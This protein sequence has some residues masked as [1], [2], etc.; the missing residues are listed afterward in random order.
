M[1]WNWKEVVVAQHGEDAKCHQNVHFKNDQIYVSDRQLNQ[2][3]PRAGLDGA[4]GGSHADDSC[5]EALAVLSSS[6]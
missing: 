6:R 2:S 4:A 1:F 3:K 5:H